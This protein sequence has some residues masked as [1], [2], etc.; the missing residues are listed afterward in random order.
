MPSLLNFDASYQLKESLQTLQSNPLRSLLSIV[1]VVC[2]V[3][4]VVAMLCIGLGAEREID[5]MLSSLGTQ[6][7]HITSQDL[8][9]EEWGK[10]LTQTQGLGLR[11]VQVLGA[12][13]PRFSL[14][15][16]GKWAVSDV[17]R[18]L[19]QP[20][21]D[22]V[23][24]SP[25]FFQ[26]M[27][28]SFRVGR[29]FTE[30]EDSRAAPVVIIGEQIAQEWFGAPAAA[31]GQEVRLDGAWF[32]IIG[33]L[34]GEALGSLKNSS[35]VTVADS[36]SDPRSQNDVRNV[37]SKQGNESSK[38]SDSLQIFHPGE[39]ILLPFRSAQLRLGPLAPIAG[40][41]RIVLKV[42]SQID[43]IAVKRNL[44]S[45]FA[46][47]HRDTNVIKV[48]SA[49]EIIKNKRATTR[50][51]TTFLL[52]VAFISLGVGGIGIANV[53]L[54]GMVE[55]IREIGLRRAIGAKRQDIMNQ[56]LIESVLVCLVGGIIG[57]VIGIVSAFFAGKFMGW[58]VVY[59]L[60]AVFVAIFVSSVVGFVSGLFPAKKASSI[61]PIEA[62][63]GRV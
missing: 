60:W 6:N 21:L 52:I 41:E 24:V 25:S 11:D 57:A 7:I 17:S 14:A 56:F 23:G 31:L 54:A 28:S 47:I 37:G 27:G 45:L 5:K 12:A 3:A 10:V 59:P 35:D 61:S 46:K 16:V 1:G 36:G 2:G 44:E 40:L 49:D 50:L 18:S 38:S 32:R 63:Q 30:F 58:S 34:A 42:P 29:T 51:F 9:P 33:V 26:I 43:P 4:S 53:M 48:V 55:R 19:A 8:T 15:T 39:V 13:F 22:V 62:L 20:K